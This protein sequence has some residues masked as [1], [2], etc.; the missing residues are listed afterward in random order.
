[1]HLADW[2]NVGCVTR[3]L[4]ARIANLHGPPPLFS[5]ELFRPMVVEINACEH[6][7]WATA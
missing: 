6:D 2:A 3:H 1:M 7:Q 4:H 5:L